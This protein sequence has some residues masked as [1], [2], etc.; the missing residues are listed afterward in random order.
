LL[1]SQSAVK[2]YVDSATAAVES[3]PAGTKM[4]FAQA[5]APTGWTTDAAHKDNVLACK[6]DSGTY[7][8]VGANKGSFTY[9]GMTNAAEASHNHKWYDFVDTANADSF[10][11]G[12]SNIAFTGAAGKTGHGPIVVAAAS[13]DGPGVDMYTNAGTSHNHVITHDGTDRPKATVG[14]IATKD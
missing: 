5:T 8:T 7:S 12:G 11:S 3:I 4:F 6:S 9:T 10:N 2:G 14:I 13:H 1:P